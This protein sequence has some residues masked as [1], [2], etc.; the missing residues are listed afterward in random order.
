MRTT[1]VLNGAA[2]RN[3]SMH[4]STFQA[5]GAAAVGDAPVSLYQGAVLGAST[6][7]ALAAGEIVR[8]TATVPAEDGVSD[9]VLQVETL[10]G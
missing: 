5:P 1:D 3:T 10:D 8:V 2:E 6:G 7:A 4:P 9:P